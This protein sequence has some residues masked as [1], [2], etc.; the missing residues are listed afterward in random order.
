[1]IERDGRTFTVRPEKIRLLAADERE[2]EPGIIQPAVYLGLVTRFVVA[3]ERGDELSVIQQNLET[4]SVDVHDMEGAPVRLVWRTDAE[5]AIKEEEQEGSGWCT[6]C[7]PSVSSLWPSRR[8]A[9]HGRVA[10]A[11]RR[12]WASA[13]ASWSSWPGRGTSIPLAIMAAYL[14]VM[15]RLGGVRVAVMES[16]A[17]RC[18]LWTWAAFVVAFLWIP[19]AIMAVYAFNSSTIHSWPIPGFT[20]HWISTAWHDEEVRTA[21]VLST[22]AALLATRLALALG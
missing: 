15:K 2:G 11:C 9:C 7:S 16:S 22:R 1:M 12:R 3:L 14:L 13:R 6:R 20:T 18:A 10:K 21:L 19:I 5:F 8:R 17:T 4:S